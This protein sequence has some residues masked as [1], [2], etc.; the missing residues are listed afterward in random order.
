MFIVSLIIIVVTAAA[1]QVIKALVNNSIPLSET[2]EFIPQVLSL[3]HIRNTGAAWSIMQGQTWFL[4]IMPLIVIFVALVY[5]YKNRRGPKLVMVSL[6]LVTGGGIGNLIDRIR[7]HE[8]ID[9]LKCELFNFPVFNFA[10]MCV[11]VGA[12]LFCVYMFFFDE[13]I[14]SKE[15]TAEAANGE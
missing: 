6:A 5:M 13:S 10:D 8:V 4:V 3:T 14:K 9:Y 15:K 12:I 11:V 1:D 7:M 2:R